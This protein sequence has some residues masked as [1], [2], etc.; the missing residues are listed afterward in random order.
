MSY[1]F[2]TR[3]FEAFIDAASAINTGTAKVSDYNHSLASIA[4]TYR[5]TAI[6]EAGRLSLDHNK[7]VL[8]LYTDD[9]NDSNSA[10]STTN[11]SEMKPGYCQ[12]IGL[13]ILD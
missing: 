13:K 6:L 9:N 4:S 12:P 5:T 8:I 11:S 3:S 1:L 7:T 2:S 10:S